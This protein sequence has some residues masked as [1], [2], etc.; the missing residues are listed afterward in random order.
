MALKAR[1][2]PVVSG[3]EELI[4]SDRR[5][6]RGLR[7]R[8]LGARARRDLA[9]AR[10]PRCRAPPG[11]A[12]CGSPASNGL[13]LERRRR[14]SQRGGMNMAT[15]SR[16][17]RS[18]HHRRRAARS[19]RCASCAS[20]SAAWCS[21]SGA[22]G[23]S[24]GRGSIILIPGD[25]ADGAGRPAHRGAGRAAAGR[26]LARQ[27]LGQGQRG[28]LL[29]RGRPAEGDHPGRA[30]SSRRPASSRRPRCA[31]C[32]ASTSSTRCWPSASKL[33]LDIQQIL[34]AADRRL[35]HQGL[36]RRDQAR[37]PERDAWCARSP[38]QAEAERERRAKVI[39]A[40]GEL[41]ASEKLLAGRRR[42]WRSS[43]RRCS[44]ATCRR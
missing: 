13:M 1:R 30:T 3:R 19:R 36:E 41:Q 14:E 37:R 42:C 25:P 12:R 26:D 17:G 8:R 43:P 44:C 21:C 29:P 28:G 4:G 34:D 38:R 5:G 31:R 39:H 11:A 18:A 16:S 9:G 10:E 2:R 35:G 27:R 40:E 6:A 33:N 23:R 15:S 20:T 7:A 22:S 32:S 24:R